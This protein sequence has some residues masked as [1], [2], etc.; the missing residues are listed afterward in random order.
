ME[1]F[2]RVQQVGD[3]HYASVQFTSNQM[4]P[5]YCNFGPAQAQRTRDEEGV[6]YAST[7]FSR[8]RSVAV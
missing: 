1:K 4:D 5:V 3:I 2:S 6:E 7:N 8:A